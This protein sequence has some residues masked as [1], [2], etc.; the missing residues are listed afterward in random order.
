M[1]VQNEETAL[2]DVQPVIDENA[3]KPSKPRK[4]KK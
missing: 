4:G 1:T 2:E 3:D